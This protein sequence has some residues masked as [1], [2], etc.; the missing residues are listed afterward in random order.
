VLA[1]R[2]PRRLA[3][4]AAVGL[5]AAVPL[6]AAGCAGD[7]DPPSAAA[8]SA[9]EAAATTTAGTADAG[10][11]AG[12]RTGAAAPA[13]SAPAATDGIPGIVRQVGPSAVAVFA[14]SA[15]GQ[16]EGS[17]VIWSSDGL[18]VTNN[19]VVEGAEDITVALA[20]GEQLPAQVEAASE[21]VDIAVLRVD[22]EGL[23]AARFADD[24]PAVGELAIAMGN[25]LGFESSVT[26]GIVSGTGRSIP[27]SSAEGEIPALVDLLQTDAAISPGNSGGPLVN[28]DGEVIGL[29]VAYIPPE[30]RAVSIGFAIPSPTVISSVEQL[31]ENGEVSYG[32]LGASLSTLTRDTADELG[33]DVRRG[34]IVSEVVPDGPADRAGLRGGDVIVRIDGDPVDVV[35]DAF[36]VI[37]RTP[38]GE[39]V[40][41]TV[42]RDG[43]EQ[44]V[45]VTLGQRPENLPG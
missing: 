32:Y 38:A 36:G 21:G 42:V 20:S 26:A 7:D 12:N 14:E 29:N 39:S 45:D 28:A 6:G 35:E 41:M 5:I 23:P 19:H 11:G 2:P 27:G 9:A 31:L 15:V 40:T 4:I 17:G 37:L 16:G 24:L 1:A 18:V 8:T 44:Q 10:A 33:V 22:R 43:E 3:R 30:A 34:V 13:G 25:P